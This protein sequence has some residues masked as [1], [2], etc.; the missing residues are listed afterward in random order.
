MD[1]LC[2]SH[3][4]LPATKQLLGSL[5]SPRVSP[6]V[7]ADLPTSEGLPRCGN[8]SSSSAPCQEIRAHTASFPLPFPFLFHPTW[9]CGDISC[10]FKC[11]RSSASFQQENYYSICRCILDVFVNYSICR[12]ILDVFV[13]RDEIHILLLLHHLGKSRVTIFKNSLSSKHLI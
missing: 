1:H 3:S 4:V 11:P 13:G 8:I 6:S 9:L 5:L 7:P 10:P 2:R 12:C